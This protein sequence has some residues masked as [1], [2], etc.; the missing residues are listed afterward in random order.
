M[1][2]RRLVVARVATVG[3]PTICSWAIVARVHS[4]SWITEPS[5]PAHIASIGGDGSE[6]VGN[7]TVTVGAGTGGDATW[8]NTILIVGNT[9]TGTLNIMGGGSVLTASVAG[10]GAASE[11]ENGNGTVTVGGGTGIAT[12]RTTPCTWDL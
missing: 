8:T 3:P 4:T 2:Q 6:D 9:G 11:F 5:R 1:A 10:I 7:G 12:G